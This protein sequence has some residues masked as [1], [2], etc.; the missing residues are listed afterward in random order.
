MNVFIDARMMG[1][2]TSRGI[3]RVI[4]E[5]LIRLLQDDSIQW[6]V[7]VRKQEQLAGLTGNFRPIVCDIPWYGFKEQLILPWI[8]FR[9]Q[10]DLIFFPHWNMPL[11]TFRPF[12]CFIHDLILFHHPDSTNISTRSMFFAKVKLVAQ[13][14]LVQ[15][16]AKRAR[17]ILVPTQ[18]VAD[19]FVRYFPQS[20]NHVRVVGEGISKLPRAS[21]SPPISAPYFLLVGG[22]YPHKRLDLVLSAWKTQQKQFPHHSLVL[23]GEM[24][25][26]RRRLMDQT[27][28]LDLERVIFEGRVD[29]DLLAHWYVHA[30]ALIFPS[31]DEGFGLPPL[32]AL[33]FG[34]PVLSS[35]IPCL[36]EVLPTGG[37]VFFRNG[38]VN[39]MIAS[40]NHLFEM[41]N[42]IRAEVT[43]GYTQACLRHDWDKTAQR[44]KQ[45]FSF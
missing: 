12:V 5:L 32:E 43:R 2:E 33:S 9:E 10:P 24:D 14:V 13:R 16:I 4:R 1:A 36:R 35:D 25:V 3:G 7:L 18:F 42:T 41:R 21:T 30:E 19:D 6:V 29:D 11:L 31:E 23:I 26:F 40:W 17:Q 20:A 37:V 8:I 45:S 22:A 27:K 38:D 34:C 44:V 39:D 15:S 28:Q